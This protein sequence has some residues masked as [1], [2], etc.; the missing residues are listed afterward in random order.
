MFPPL[1]FNNPSYVDPLAGVG[2]LAGDSKPVLFDVDGDGDADLLVGATDG[3]LAYFMNT[4]SRSSP[5]FVKQTGP[6]DG[7]NGSPFHAI[8]AFSAGGGSAPALGDLNLDGFVDL[9][10]GSSSGRLSIHMGGP[11]PLAP[12]GAPSYSA[13][14]IP[15]VDF[16]TSL[17]F[18]AGAGS[19]PSLVDVDG[20][21]HLDIVVGAADGSVHI[22]HSVPTGTSTSGTP[23]SSVFTSSGR[24]A[25]LGGVTSPSGD[26][27][28]ALV[29]MDNDGDVD[30]VLGGA[31]GA[32]LF[33]EN[34]GSE[35][36]PVFTGPVPSGARN[37]VDG[38]RV[39]AGGS[40]PAF[41]DI[42][43][44]GRADMVVGSSD[45]LIRYF[46]NDAGGGGSGSGGGNG[47]GSSGGT[48]GAGAGVSG[49]LILGPDGQPVLGPTTGRPQVVTDERV[50][51]GGSI[52]GGPIGVI[53]NANGEPVLDA[54]GKP[55]VIT[56]PRVPQ[57]G[58]IGTSGT[59]V[60]LDGDGEPLLVDGKPLVV[61]D[62][63]VPVGGS[64]GSGGVG[65][66]V[67]SDGVPLRDSDGEMF[68]VTD[69][70][71]PDGGSIGNG[72]VILDATS[73]PLLDAS[74]SPLVA[75]HPDVPPGGSIAP[76]GVILD[77]D[78]IPVL[79]ANGTPMPVTD[80][81]V[82]FPGGS[83]GGGGGVGVILG[84]D[85]TPA[86][87]ASGEAQVVTD[88]RVPSD[89][90]IGPGGGLVPGGGL[91][92]DVAGK[93]L[94]GADGQP[95]VVVDPRVPLGGSIGP[96]P[97]DEGGDDTGFGGD[98]FDFFPVIGE[99]SRPPVGSTGASPS[100]LRLVLTL[101]LAPLPLLTTGRGPIE[102][103]LSA[104]LLPLLGPV[105]SALS[106][107]IAGIAAASAA[108]LAP[109]AAASR[110]SA[111][112]QEAITTA[113]AAGYA[114]LQ[115]YCAHHEEMLTLAAQA[116]AVE[117]ECATM[118][119]KKH[120][121]V[122][123]RDPPSA[124]SDA[125][126]I[127]FDLTMPPK[128]RRRLQ[129][130][131]ADAAAA[132]A[133]QASVRLACALWETRA[134]GGAPR[135]DTGVLQPAGF[136]AGLVSSEGVSAILASPIRR[137][138]VSCPDPPS[139]PPLP[140]P[141]SPPPSP[142]SP[143]PPSPPATPPSP[144]R[145]PP[146]SP[147][148]QWDGDTLID[149]DGSRLTGDEEGRITL[150]AILIGVIILL[151]CLLMLCCF[152]RQSHSDSEEEKANL[153]P[154]LL[155]MAR[156]TWRGSS[157]TSSTPA[158]TDIPMLDLSVK[159]DVLQTGGSSGDIVR[160]AL[161]P[162]EGSLSPATPKYEQN[163]Y[164]IQVQVVGSAA[165]SGSAAAG[166]SAVSGTSSAAAS[167]S[168][169]AGRDKEDEELALPK[170][171]HPSRLFRAKKGNKKKMEQKRKAA[172]EE[173]ST[174]GPSG[175]SREMNHGKMPQQY[176]YD[177]VHQLKAEL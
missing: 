115:E 132:A 41:T 172:A 77:E 82:P 79:D 157:T 88:P 71:V 34:T 155:R 33:F 52:G 102:A 154:V 101:D 80:P 161:E 99:E 140:P 146:A 148:Q 175:P 108:S 159:R 44:D 9:V 126:E 137:E 13:N 64:I 150:I 6:S 69:P 165:A 84:A 58:S 11:N 25:E 97:D 169:A 111:T 98:G 151:C 143:P 129:T 120:N 177:S 76:V 109:S 68:V 86:L 30:L 47:G 36:S 56:D 121:G 112:E 55:I 147:G 106:V 7:T 107:R 54:D 72:G 152:W 164:D 135:D 141:I 17:V 42:N 136:G 87:D 173:S 74:G 95:V 3:S 123:T 35:R 134:A 110:L 170:G 70:R 162:S 149:T 131:D 174:A 51:S 156:K 130:A 75:T 117:Y 158:P 105:A 160:G 118:F 10:L 12:F 59:G 22:L 57:G 49:G 78:G 48:G 8:D 168:A 124:V 114:S 96:D 91:I 167:G 153:E 1:F 45:G 24:G 26:A 93:P 73:G 14:G 4:G 83:I 39:P 40:A 16:A 119:V 90:S 125:T 127:T 5:N 43:G 37:P 15:L 67:D 92:L 50:P 31:D 2:T 133:Q 142:S 176:R 145:N 19:T 139:S 28:P 122:G 63:R 65:V 85:G 27:A 18:D 46:G 23:A 62:P 144:P 21:G 81:R 94:L 113:L 166:G 53:L 128:S 171:G 61:T 163:V 138:R 100:G 32:L 103:A 60:I 104:W 38:V 116:Y 66:V 89:G 29:D 20:N